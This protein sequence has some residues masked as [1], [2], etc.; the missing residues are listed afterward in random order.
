[1][2]GNTKTVAADK[3]VKTSIK[4]GRE[5]WKRAHIRAMDEGMDL[6]DLVAKALAAYLGGAQ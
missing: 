5:L 1:M 3:P 4:L 6:Q 2:K